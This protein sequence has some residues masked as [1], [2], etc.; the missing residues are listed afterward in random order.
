MRTARSAF[1]ANA[2]LAFSLAY[3][4]RAACASALASTAAIVTFVFSDVGVEVAAALSF[5]NVCACFTTSF[6]KSMFLRLVT[7]GT[8]YGPIPCFTPKS[9]HTR[10]DLFVGCFVATAV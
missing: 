5:A 9:V 2:S 3:F 4:V 10:S 8:L 6:L 1:L 7:G